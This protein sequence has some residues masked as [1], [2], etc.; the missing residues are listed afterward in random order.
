M[1]S[2]SPLSP[3]QQTWPSTHWPPPLGISDTLSHTVVTGTSR[4][5]DHSHFTEDGIK[6]AKGNVAQADPGL[7]PSQWNPKA[8]V[9]TVQVWTVRGSPYQDQPPWEVACQ[10]CETKSQRVLSCVVLGIRFRRWTGKIG[11]REA[12]CRP[13]RHLSCPWREIWLDFH[14][15]IKV[16]AG[17]QLRQTHRHEENWGSLESHKVNRSY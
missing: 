2:S 6:F 16:R 1:L 13:A 7:N 11:F 15:A 9:S 4:C 5:Y 3:P 10:R 12:R 8:I 14:M 17:S